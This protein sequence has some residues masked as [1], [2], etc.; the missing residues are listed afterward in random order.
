MSVI[1]V[2]ELV[3]CSPT[4]FDDAVQEAVTRASQTVRHLSG[5]DILGFTAKVENG[6]IVEYRADVK[7]AF[8]VEERK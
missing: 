3:G 4:S 6:R 1:K 5:V 2:I 7:V 8:E